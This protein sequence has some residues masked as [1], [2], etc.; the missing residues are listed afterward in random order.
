[1]NNEIKLIISKFL[2]I[3][4]SEINDETIIDS[5]VVKGSVLFHRMISRINDLFNVEITNYSSIKTYKDLI[6]EI[7]ILQSQK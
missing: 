6:S 7:N 4:E 1:M 5:S 2:K 3:N